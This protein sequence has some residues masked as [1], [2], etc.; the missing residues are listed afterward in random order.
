MGVVERIWC[1][2]PN[3]VFL[4]CGDAQSVPKRDSWVIRLKLKFARSD[5]ISVRMF[6]ISPVSPRSAI[7]SLGANVHI[8]QFAQQHK[9]QTLRI[10]KTSI[11]IDD[12]QS[13]QHYKRR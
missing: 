8:F 7:V 1:W 9:S 2:S 13:S 3:G 10:G 11:I 12:V 6:R 5:S 4:R